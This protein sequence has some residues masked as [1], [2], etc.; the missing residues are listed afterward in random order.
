MLI[1]FL[2]AMETEA[3]PLLGKVEIVATTK[4]GFATLHECAYQGRKFFVGLCGIGK[5][6]SASG[7]AGIIVAHP[8]ID[9]YINLGVGGSLDANKA[10]IL[11]AVVGKGYVQHDMDTSPI[12]DPKAFLSGVN[13]IEVPGDKA[14]V[15]LL[16]KACLDKGISVYQ[17]VIAS[18]DNFV[19]DEEIK[20]GFVR[21]FNAISVDMEAAAYA[22]TAYVYGKPFTALRVI[23]DAVD[24]S[25]E[26][27]RYK[28]QCAESASEVALH[29]LSIVE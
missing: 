27:M 18:G 26:Y 14:M 3:K 10:P 21:D 29:L 16:S 15:E 23:S 19:V 5:V 12:G 6:L 7:L 25:N 2:C 11:S 8:E 17:G 22:E 9:S 13:L 28:G 1:C 20:A 4:L 24:H